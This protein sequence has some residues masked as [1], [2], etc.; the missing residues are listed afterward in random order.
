MSNRTYEVIVYSKTEPAETY[1]FT[2]RCRAEA[3]AAQKSTERKVFCVSV[4]DEEGI[5]DMTYFEAG[6][7]VDYPGC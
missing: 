6:G 5:Y 7:E 3:F 4:Q 1:R 2:A